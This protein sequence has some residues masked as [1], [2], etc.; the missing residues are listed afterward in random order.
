MPSKSV[1]AT[2]I[3]YRNFP[4]KTLHQIRASYSKNECATQ[5][6]KVLWNAFTTL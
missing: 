6:N 1:Y 2:F 4:A 5:I 3:A